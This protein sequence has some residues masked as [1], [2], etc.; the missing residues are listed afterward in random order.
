MKRLS[1]KIIAV[2][3][4]MCMVLPIVP[5]WALADDIGSEEA[6]VGFKLDKVSETPQEVTLR[7]S[8]T[9]GKALCFDLKIE[10]K[11]GFTCTNIET[12]DAIRDFAENHPDGSCAKNPET[13]M[14][15]F[16]NT[17]DFSAPADIAD[18]T[19][20]KENAAGVTASDFS[21]IITAC[22]Q[23]DS[24]GN[25]IQPA[26]SVVNA[27]PE[28]HSHVSTGE[29]KKLSESTCLVQGESVAY[30]K[31]CGE[32]AEHRYDDLLP[33]TV[34]E[35][36]KAATCTEDG[37]VLKY[38]TVCNTEISKT[39][40]KKLDHQNAEFQ[41]KDP[42]CTEDGYDGFLCPD[43]GEI[44]DK[45]VIPATNHPNKEYQHKDAT[46]T[47]D[48]Y[49]RYYCPDCQQ[50]VDVTVIPA[51]N[52]PNKVHQHKDPSC[53]ENGYDRYY[54]PD[55]EQYLD[56]KVLPATDHKHTETWHKDATCTED[57][58]DRI[59]CTDCKTIIS[60]VTIKATGHD[61]VE[62]KKD[63]TCTEDGYYKKYC[64][65][66]S[67]VFESVTYPMTGHQHTKNVIT[68]AT[69][70]EDGSIK[71]V[72]EDCGTIVKTT[73]LKAEGHKLINDVKAA[74]CLNDGY[75]DI[76]CSKCGFV[77]VHNVIKATGHSWSEWKVI[78]EPTYRSVGVER[79][80]CRGCGI[81]EERDIPMIVVP[82]EQIIITPGEDFTIHCKK[83]DRLQATVTPDEAMFSAKIV[84]ESSNP[85]VVSV[86]DDGTITA[87]RRGTA[88]ITAKTEDGTVSDSIKITVDYSTIQWIIVYILFGWIWYL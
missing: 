84:W 3:L 20:S 37:Y 22:Y 46:C 78:K 79:K 41:H 67:E 85:K 33:H 76:K 30:C 71:V 73:V 80:T 26:V 64:S 47:E 83:T 65:K 68:D 45:T 52:H 75:M 29:F 43:C 17:V 55:C 35:V 44:L 72:C 62:D 15:S 32:I 18:F 66:C 63:A 82:V 57:G 1:L 60:D 7:L 86:S 14:F 77:Q 12:S 51:T 70:T 42:T 28:V 31:E 10:A 87:L 34:K 49:D 9:D 81:Y 6:S 21:V 5:A 69:C 4:V 38:C 53:T 2:I 16:V 59:Y 8:L 23:T 13:G 39:V 25:D 19:Y 36:T 40:L 58:Y 88:T 61:V 74:T 56:E 11:S 48:G 27:V 50:Y 24:D 54:C